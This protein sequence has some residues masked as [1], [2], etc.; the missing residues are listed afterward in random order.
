MQFFQSY[1]A[2]KVLADPKEI[3][4][5]WFTDKDGNLFFLYLERDMIIVKETDGTIYD[6]L[7]E[8]EADTLGNWLVLHD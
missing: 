8:N 5:E 3:P 2:T 7:F 1:R 6:L 4:T